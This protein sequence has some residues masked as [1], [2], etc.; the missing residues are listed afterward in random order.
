MTTP[1]QV[2]RIAFRAHV[3]KDRF[4][5]ESILADDFN[6]T[7]PLDNRIDRKT[8]LEI[9]WPNSE[10]MERFDEMFAS[11]TG[12]RACIGYIGTARGGKRFRNCE[13]A[14]VRDGKLVSVEVY[15]GW[16]VP[17]RLAD[18]THSDDAGAGRP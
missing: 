9:C 18:G 10:D 7:C 8:Y 4:A 11:E 13:I 16:N 3:D 14:T 2:F 17:H 12:D 15:F 6:F 5:I 1:L